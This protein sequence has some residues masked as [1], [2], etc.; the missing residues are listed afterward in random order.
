MEASMMFCTRTS[1]TLMELESIVVLMVTSLVVARTI[2]IGSL[3]QIY[4][5]TFNYTY[6]LALYLPMAFLC[7]KL[8]SLVSA[9]ANFFT[10]VTLSCLVIH[11]A[12]ML[13][14]SILSAMYQ[15]LSKWGEA[16]TKHWTVPSMYV[17]IIN[18][19][20]KSLTRVDADV[21]KKI[22]LFFSF[23]S[24][25]IGLLLLLF[26]LLV[27]LLLLLLLLIGWKSHRSSESKV[28]HST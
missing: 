8:T 28:N 7:G 15:S 2:V 24:L 11:V 19:T 5:R 13:E 17:K 4:F 1:W 3:L 22:Q 14:I 12:G 16:C 9:T 10:S 20:L 6:L 26:V 21:H 25:L 23:S 18:Q 27:L